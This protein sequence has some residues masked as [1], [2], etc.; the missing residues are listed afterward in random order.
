MRK[1]KIIPIAK[2][3]AEKIRSSMRDDFGHELHTASLSGRAL[4]RFCLTDGGPEQKH[5]LFSYL[6]VENINPYAEIG[7][8]F[9]HDE[10]EQYI[11]V[12]TVPHDLA[13]RKFLTIRGYSA[14]Q[15]L[16]KGYMAKGNEI[17]ETIERLFENAEVESI[18]INDASSGCYF[19][20]IVRA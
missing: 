16:I 10:C 20:K 4:C 6:P 7:P 17:V 12:D 18:H 1:F 5:I 9:I 11:D 2:E 15:N 3:Y 14:G 19:L 13:T 8:V